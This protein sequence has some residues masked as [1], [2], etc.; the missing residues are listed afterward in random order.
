MHSFPVNPERR[1]AAL[2]LALANRRVIV[3]RPGSQGNAFVQRLHDLGATP[4]NIP[5]IAIA[6]PDDIVALDAALDALSTYDWIAFTS[7][8]AVKAVA[9]RL[10]ERGGVA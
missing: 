9:E 1:E 2:R 4:I 3:T 7:A 10:R 5:V 8:N 6:P